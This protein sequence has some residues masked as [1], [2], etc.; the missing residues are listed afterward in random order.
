MNPMKLLLFFALLFSTGFAQESN[1]EEIK[2]EVKPTARDHQIKGRLEAILNATGWFIDP[3]AEVKEGV[4]FLYGSTN[5]EE[6]KKWAGSLARNIEAVT[7]VV[8]K[9]AITPTS[10]WSVQPMVAV[11]NELAVDFFKVLPLLIFALVVLVITYFVSK[12][13]IKAAKKTLKKRIASS[14]LLEVIS[15]IFGFFVFLLGLYI[16]FKILGLTT[17]ALTI[18]GGTGVIGVVLGIAFRDITENIL[19]SIFLSVHNPF[20]NGDLV[21]IGELEGYVQRLT[22]RSTVLLSL[23]GNHIQ[24]PNS[25][26]YKSNIKN[27]TANPARREFFDILVDYKADISR[28]QEIAKQVLDEHPAILKTPE[29]L[30]LVN[31]LEKSMTNIRIYFWIDGTAHS[32]IK[33]QSS[34]CRLVKSAFQ[35]NQIE[36]PGEE[37]SVQAPTKQPDAVENRSEAGLDSDSNELQMQADASRKPEKGEADLLKN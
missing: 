5:N 16:I 2:V 8:N 14:L 9:I 15:R 17:I 3:K 4:V 10:V 1:S 37:K 33:V 22:I 32:W 36:M 31:R 29:S 20:K 26:V 13:A 12:V 28:A 30:V 7:A 18:L 35:K 21:S 24:I 25:T 27:Y 11:L 23:E 19:A 6:H 34:L